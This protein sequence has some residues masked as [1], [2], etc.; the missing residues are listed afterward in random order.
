MGKGYK[1][2]NYLEARKQAYTLPYSEHMGANH[3]IRKEGDVWASNRWRQEGELRVTFS[4]I[5]LPQEMMGT[6]SYL[7]IVFKPKN[8]NADDGSAVSTSLLRV[9]NT[10]S[11]NNS[12][13]FQLI[14]AIYLGIWSLFY[15]WKIYAI[16]VPHPY[17]VVID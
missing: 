4:H 7:A 3:G 5:A 17:R 8:R 1:E 14:L 16:N 9:Y 11:N 12:T 10:F 2:I 15:S 6:S 13:T